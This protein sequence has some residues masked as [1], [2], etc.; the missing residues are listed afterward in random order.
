M[1]IGSFAGKVLLFFGLVGAAW[2]LQA[3]FFF[4]T[5]DPCFWE[6]GNLVLIRRNQPVG[7]RL[8]G[9]YHHPGKSL[10]APCDQVRRP[11]STS[12]TGCSTRS[13]GF[14]CPAPMRKGA[15]NRPL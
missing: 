11:F 4:S 13:S 12:W 7:A 3:Q 9:S 15:A 14:P 5:P 6:G 1:A 2:P 10:K 8:G